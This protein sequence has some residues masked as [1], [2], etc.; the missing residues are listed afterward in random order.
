MQALKT[1]GKNNEL[2][3]D[4][5][6]WKIH[7]DMDMDVMHRCEYTVFALAPMLSRRCI[8]CLLSASQ[9]AS[10]DMGVTLMCCNPSKQPTFDL[11]YF[12]QG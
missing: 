3:G 11:H 8:L 9:P 12:E 4:W 7:L 1:K 5:W 10:L 2:L 6:H